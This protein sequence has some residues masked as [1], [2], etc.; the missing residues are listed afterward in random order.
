M[1]FI[2]GFVTVYLALP[3][4]IV[5]LILTWFF[6]ERLSAAG[7]TFWTIV[8]AGSALWVFPDLRTLLHD[9]RALV[10]S[11]A[12]YIAAGVV[13]AF[14]R[15]YMWLRKIRDSLIEKREEYISKHELSPDYF[16]RANDKLQEFDHGEGHASDISPARR[17]QLQYL[18]H[19]EALCKTLTD[20]DRVYR[21][22][23]TMQELVDYI[24]PRAANNKSRIIFWM[25]YW[26][27]SII[28]YIVRDLFVDLWN[29]IY[30]RVADLF[31]RVSNHV[32]RDVY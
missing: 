25:A 2:I 1:E 19:L 31:Q 6:S 26:P 23:N 13:W 30:R 14:L 29:A 32:F 11:F 9:P 16:S 3:F 18:S 22:L 21:S 4:F 17:M 12:L 28:W 24:R 8:M 27:L 7:A 20:G 5:A 10:S 15:W